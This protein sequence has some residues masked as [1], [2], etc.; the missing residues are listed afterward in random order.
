METRQNLTFLPEVQGLRTVALI[1]VATFHIWFGRVSGGVD[2]FLVISAYLMT[3]SLT[4]RS[5]AGSPVRP[6]SFLL[7][8]FARLLPAAVGVV[9]LTLIAVWVFMPTPT[10]QTAGG[11]A[12]AAVFF[13]ENVHLQ[14]AMV[15]YYAEDR[16]TASAFQQY[17]SLSIQAQAFVLWAL[18]HAIAAIAA[19]LTRIPVRTVLLVGF[20]L[21]FALSFARSVLLTDINQAYA[22]FDT[23][24]RLWEFAAGSLFALASPWLRLPDRVRGVASWV[25]LL[26][27]VTCGFL[28]PVESRFP[29]VAA[30]WPVIA[31]G[32]VIVSA[33]P[34]TTFGAD[35][36]L[37]RPVLERAG[38]YTY[39]LYLV[40]WP[41]LVIMTEALPRD[42]PDGVRTT[43]VA[44]TSVV[45]A[46]AV[47]RLI[48]RPAAKLVV[49]AAGDDRP[50]SPV[51]AWWARSKRPAIA[52]VACFAIGAATVGAG[53][54]LRDRLL[55]ADR[56]AFENVDL[57]SLGANADPYLSLE[58]GT[59]PSLADAKTDWVWAG[60][61]CADDD[62]YRVRTCQL[63]LS[64]SGS[65][66]R[67][68]LVVGN[69]HS[70]QLA[71]AVVQTMAVE[72]D[73]EARIQITAACAISVPAPNPGPSATTSGASPSSTSPTSDPTPSSSSAR[74]RRSTARSCRRAS[75]PGS[76][77]CRRSR[78][79]RRS[80][81]CAT[82]RA[83][84]VRCSRA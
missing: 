59:I 23:S 73:W 84:S 29:G 37:R 47:T 31:A 12:L 51:R 15:D 48:E 74:P 55:A 39:S 75:P 62:P 34:P 17:W 4:A 19:K 57:S 61:N 18:L 13:T 49:R 1:L 33:G 32:L 3:R 14:N 60:E 5:E 27:I 67:Q 6:V 77:R 58:A 76:P 11:D 68:L 42:V 82:I 70:G 43:L 24:A 80:S 21:L 8:K 69:S 2:V 66:T 38:G 9:V 54:V 65:P 22:Y 63:A 56:A 79:T 7:R 26:A 71:G 44:V 83:S 20:G 64:Q 36:L 16:S 53:V 30:L 72:P 25:G 78:R 28:L 10:W 41:A 45:A 40:H 50:A 81:S 46:I 35:R 52:I